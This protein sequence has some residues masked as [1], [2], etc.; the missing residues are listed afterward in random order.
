MGAE[1]D[2]EG[3]LVAAGLRDHGDGLEPRCVPVV[4]DAPP[5]RPGEDPQV[6]HHQG[7]EQ[8]A[9]KVEGGEQGVL[10]NAVTIL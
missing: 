4:V 8:Q 3:G 2:L 5:E 7:L 6:A 9:Q 1:L 10:R